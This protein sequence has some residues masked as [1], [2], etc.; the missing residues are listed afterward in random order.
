MSVATISPIALLTAEE[1][2]NR[3]DPGHPEELVRGR[4][5]PM[6]MP[7]PRHGEICSKANRLLGVHVDEHKAG[8]VLCN[9]AGVVTA[10]SPDT[11]RGADISFY[12]YT[13]LP[14]GPL[15]DRYLDVPPDLVVEVLSPSDRWSKVLAKVSE[16]LDAGTS[17]V[18]VLDDE[19]RLAY[20]YRADDGPRILAAEDELTIP[21]LLPDFRVRVGQ[22][23]E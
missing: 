14:K 13:R 20:V 9:D 8:R 12:S 15:P 23:F 11:V 5:V 16:Y 7:K 18:V 3:P 17:V 22:F 21:D 2:A 10:R 4:I 1:F 6:P 19:R